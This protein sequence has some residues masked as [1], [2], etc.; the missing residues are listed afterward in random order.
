MGAIEMVVL[1]WRFRGPG[2]RG[3]GEDIASLERIWTE[4]TTSCS[5]RVASL[6]VLIQA[7]LSEV[8]N[9]TTCK[10]SRMEPGKRIVGNHRL[11]ASIRFSCKKAVNEKNARKQ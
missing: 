11:S 9:R 4:T 5:Q 2:V 7:L 6:S 10:I 3:T 1:I 8:L